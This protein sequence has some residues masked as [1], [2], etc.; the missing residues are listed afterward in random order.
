MR[1]VGCPFLAEDRVLG[2]IADQANVILV[3]FHAEAT[4]DK[5][6]IARYL[7]ERDPTLLGSCRCDRDSGKVIASAANIQWILR[8]TFFNQVF[9]SVDE[10]MNFFR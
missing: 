5:Q 4:A 2:E 10:V 9:F 1:S 6:M 8:C 7:D 3:D